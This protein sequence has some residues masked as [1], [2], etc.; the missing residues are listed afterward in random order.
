MKLIEWLA[1]T[2]L[3][4]TLWESREPRNRLKFGK[5]ASAQKAGASS[6]TSQY[7][8]DI[9]ASCCGIPPPPAAVGRSSNTASKQLR[10]QYTSN[11]AVAAFLRL[12]LAA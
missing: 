7:D 4:A 3:L 2:Q 10:T 9:D 1:S 6:F 12:S 8:R 5:R 11:S